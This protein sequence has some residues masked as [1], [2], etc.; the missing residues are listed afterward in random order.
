MSAVSAQQLRNLLAS[1]IWTEIGHNAIRIDV[2]HCSDVIQVGVDIELGR[3]PEQ[4]S[5]VP[6]WP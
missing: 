5:A 3:Q 2:I 4:L 6:I 1:L